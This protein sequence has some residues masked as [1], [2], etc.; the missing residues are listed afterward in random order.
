MAMRRPST[1]SSPLV[2]WIA[3]D[4]I[5]ISVDLPAPLSP[6]SPTISP[7]AIRRSTPC[8]AVKAPYCLVVPRASITGG[9]STALAGVVVIALPRVLDVRALAHLGEVG[10]RRVGARAVGEPLRQR[11]AMR[12]VLVHPVERVVA[13]VVEAAAH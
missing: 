4:R 3:P 9:T 1:S 2:G 10:L 12:E 7:G 5:L 6:T 8:S 13:L 11:L